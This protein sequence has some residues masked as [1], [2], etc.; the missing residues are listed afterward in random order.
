M[1]RDRTYFIHAINHTNR[2]MCMLYIYVFASVQH[3]RRNRVTHAYTK[4]IEFYN[5]EQ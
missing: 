3:R 4:R 2:Y 5:H 1:Q